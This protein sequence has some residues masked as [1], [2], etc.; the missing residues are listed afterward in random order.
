MS[1]EAPWLRHNMYSLHAY[2]L[3]Q[4]LHKATP[5]K[6]LTLRCCPLRFLLS[7]LAL[8]KSGVQLVS[9]GGDPR[10]QYTSKGHSMSGLDCEQ[11]QLSN[12]TPG[13]ACQSP[14]ECLWL[15]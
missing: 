12:S 14:S 11:L 2:K 10:L 3:T 6:V 9:N 15:Q 1:N 5:F 4:N 7:D 8:L 13:R